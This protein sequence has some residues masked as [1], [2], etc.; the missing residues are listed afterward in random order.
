MDDVEGPTANSTVGKE[1]EGCMECVLVPVLEALILVT[2]LM[3]HSLVLIILVRRQRGGRRRPNGTDTLLLALSVA[4]LLLLLCLP[5][6][7]AAT[8]LNRWPFGIYLCKA[9]S[10]LGAA[11]SSAS[12][13]TLAA[14]A[15]TRFLTVVYPTWAYRSQMQR[16]LRLV[17]SGLWVP[18]I[19]L[20]AP[21]FAFR[22]LGPT[23]Q[24]H[25]FAFLSDI[26]QL[27]Y[28][29]VHFLIAFALPLAIIVTMYSKIYF[30]LH[31][32]RREGRAPQLERYQNQV[33]RTSGLLVLAFT[34]CWLPSY[35]LM[36]VMLG[37]NTANVPHY[38]P[39]AI[40]ARLLA[41]SSTV[42]N[43]ILYVFMSHKFRADLLN[44]VKGI[45]CGIHG[46]CSCCRGR[47]TYHTRKRNGTDPVE[48][49][50]SAKP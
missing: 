31:R 42:A 3:G 24:L 37:R 32:T 13:F 18:A 39:V 9:V 10:F 17:V 44:V 48:L 15:V 28:G 46:D 27:V 35:V 29:I 40:L 45:W 23:T 47:G 38:G 5:F 12:A 22:A 19:A 6:H 50:P 4:D 36:F 2:G 8:A 16:W 33:T 49:E 1:E 20:A 41:I 14:L 30:F 21:Q 25:C 11:C 43:P 34:L 7:T 26:S